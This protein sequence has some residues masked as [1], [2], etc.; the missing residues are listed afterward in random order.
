MTKSLADYG[1][2]T[3]GIDE[4]T[5]VALADALTHAV[6]PELGVDMLNLGLVYDLQ[7]ADDGTYHL[8]MLLT[9]IGC[10]L[11][12]Y[13]EKMLRHAMELVIGDA[14]L[15]VQFRF[16]PAWSPDRMTRVAKMTLGLH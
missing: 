4:A 7:V 15:T 1:V 6:D 9:T 13:L 16:T 3:A 2:T 8:Q 10:P 11:T 14:T 5:S 12:D